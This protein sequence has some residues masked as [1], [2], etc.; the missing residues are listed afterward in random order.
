MKLENP[1]SIGELA[2]MVDGKVIGDEN[3][4]VKGI[5]EIHR[6]EVGDLTF[7]DHPKYYDK[8]LNSAASYVIINKMVDAPAGKSL[9]FFVLILENS[10]NWELELKCEMPLWLP[11]YT[12][13]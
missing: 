4:L 8:A 13:L 3:S 12:V 7:V 2:K 1:I 5:N 9:I 11:T 6:V 10:S